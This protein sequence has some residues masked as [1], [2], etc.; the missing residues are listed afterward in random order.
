MKYRRII[1][2]CGF[3]LSLVLCALSLGGC[4]LLFPEDPPPQLIIKNESFYNITSVEFWEE[5]PEATAIAKK[6][7]WAFINMWTDMEHYLEHL[8][9]YLVANAEYEVVTSKIT[10]NPPLMKDTTVIPYDGS[11]SY[12]LNTDKNYVARVN[13][14]QSHVYLSDVKDTIYVFNGEGL[15]EKE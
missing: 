3:A 15:T 5:T 7:G 11:R 6:A 2:A 4:D 9:E 1:T 13:G 14:W 8:A 10:Q 12:N